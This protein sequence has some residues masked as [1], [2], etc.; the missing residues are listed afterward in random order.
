MMH[1]F[2]RIGFEPPNLPFPSQL[3]LNLDPDLKHGGR[4]V[5]NVHELRAQLDGFA[6][7]LPVSTAE[8]QNG[9]A[10]TVA[11]CFCHEFVFE[12]GEGKAVV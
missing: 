10:C 8:V 9:Q 5:D 11:N 4:D 2:R 7:I 1:S 6:S 12:F 3:L